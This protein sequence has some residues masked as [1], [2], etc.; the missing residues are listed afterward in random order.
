MD[1][2]GVYGFGNL[3]EEGRTILDFCKNQNLKISNTL[4][5]KPREQRITYKSGMTETQIDYVLY[6]PRRGLQIRD[7]ATI[8]GECCLTQHRLLGA[9]FLVSDFVP[10]RWRV[11]KKPKV[12]K[13]KDEE[14]RAEFEAKFVE[15]LQR[16]DL[17]WNAVQESL[18]EAC[19]E[20][21]GV[22]T[23]R[24]GAKERETW[25]WNED[26]KKAIK[27]KKDAF[28]MWQSSGR[29]DDRSFI[30]FYQRYPRKR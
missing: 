1:V 16:Q 28:K 17:S 12:W 4:F 27:N 2:M 19:H 3:N 24:R 20:V 9:K 25:W 29:E 13:L 6:R 30:R 15:K 7:C 18:S 26:V 23:G 21:C 5:Q 10:R 14:R 8:P 11:V 22:T